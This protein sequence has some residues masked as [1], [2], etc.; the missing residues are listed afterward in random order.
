MTFELD[1]ARLALVGIVAFA[2]AVEAALGFGA[3]VITVALASFFLPLDAILPAL[4]PV[5]LCLS[6]SLVVRTQRFVEWRLLWREVVGFIALGIPL[7]LA[8]YGRVEERWLKLVLGVVVA[9]LG[10]LQLRAMRRETAPWASE[11]RLARTSDRL[12]VER[13]AIEGRG[14]LILAGV[15][16]GAFATG[17]PLIVYVLGRRF[18]H[19]KDGFRATLSVLWLVFNLV[20]LITYALSDR[21]SKESLGLSVALAIGMIAGAIVGEIAF[22]RVSPQRFRVFVF[23]MLVIAGVVLVARNVVG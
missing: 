17:G 20:L 12:S 5:N 15:I 22:N 11:E 6:A 2:F 9:G 7:G 18:E 21:L 14:L 19:N 8:L 13:I 3:T 4:V 16:H 10:L 1:A 23:G